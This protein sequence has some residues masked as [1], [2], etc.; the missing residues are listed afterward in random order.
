MAK[1]LIGELIGRSGD[2]TY[3]LA[4][5]RNPTVVWNTVIAVIKG[6][7]FSDN[8]AEI[9]RLIHYSER[10]ELFTSELE[11]ALSYYSALGVAVVVLDRADLLSE[12]FPTL[13]KGDACEQVLRDALSSA[14]RNGNISKYLRTHK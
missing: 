10:K 11:A 12:F 1:I 9:L 5:L 3:I 6:A 14:K 7:V 13:L 2:L 8:P 4:L